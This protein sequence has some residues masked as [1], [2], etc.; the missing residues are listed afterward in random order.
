MRAFCCYH[1]ASF[2]LQEYLHWFTGVFFFK[3]LL[4]CSGS[5]WSGQLR[6]LCF[7]TSYVSDSFRSSQCSCKV[8]NTIKKQCDFRDRSKILFG[9]TWLWNN[10]V[11]K[12]VLNK[13]W[14]LITIRSKFT[15]LQ[16]WRDCYERVLA[17]H[18]HL[19]WWKVTIFCI[20]KACCTQQS[21]IFI[22]SRAKIFGF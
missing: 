9:N 13:W 8:R 17:M 14:V 21:S 20:S 15:F 22:L 10:V 6:C 7:C 19:G 12:V 3:L 11:K 18:L 16:R 2:C 4:L 5:W 1:T